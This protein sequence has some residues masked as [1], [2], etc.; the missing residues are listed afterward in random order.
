[1]LTAAR[2]PTSGGQYYWVAVLA[3]RAYR[4]YLSY[5]TGW[6]CAITWQTSIAGGAYLGGTLI[7]ALF[8]LNM[9]NYVYERWHGSLLTIIF[10][11]IAVVCNTFFARA[12]PMLEVVFVICHILGVFIFVP[13]WALSTTRSVGGS[14]LVE[15]YNPSGWISNGVATW[16]G[17]LGPVTA[18]IGFDCSVHMGKL[19]P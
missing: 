5:I 16:V 9:P 19:T 11:L 2:I 17:S 8:V 4:R 13:V 12:L 7:Q 10:L 1:L 18:L 15:F 14:P 3:P 6:L